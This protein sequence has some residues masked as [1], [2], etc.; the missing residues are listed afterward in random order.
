MCEGS[1]FQHPSEESSSSFHQHL[2]HAS[3]VFLRS[4]SPEVLNIL[5]SCVVSLMLGML[6]YLLYANFVIGA[7]ETVLPVVVL[8]VINFLLVV[9]AVIS[10]APYV[11]R[12]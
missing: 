8:Q 9:V 11:L 10:S 1:L 12:A 5:V 4:L 3:S 7:V 6:L 2:V